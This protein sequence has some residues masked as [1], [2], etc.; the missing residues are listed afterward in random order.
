MIHLINHDT[1]HKLPLFV[2][3]IGTGIG[4]GSIDPVFTW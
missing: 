1:L 3:S 4:N 2:E